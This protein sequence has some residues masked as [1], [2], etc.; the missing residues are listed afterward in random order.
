[1]GARFAA[2]NWQ[3]LHV[4]LV[5]DPDNVEAVS[6]AIEKAK[7]RADKPSIIICHTKIGYGSPLEGSEKCHGAPLG[8]ENLQKTKEKLGWPCEEAFDCPKEV[9]EHCRARK[10]KCSGKRCSRNTNMRIPSSPRNIRW[11]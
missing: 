1:M 7:A 8:E 10:R 3:V 6:D 2:Q 11:P 5:T 9:F 4:D